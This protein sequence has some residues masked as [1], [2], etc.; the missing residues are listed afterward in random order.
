MCDTIVALGN[1][2]EDGTTIFAKN[3]D[4]EPNEAQGLIYIPRKDHD[5]SEIVKC[6]YIEVPQVPQTYEVLL[7]V[8]YWMWGAEMGVN[9][10]GVCIG[11]EAVFSKI[12]YNDTG[13]LGMDLLRL[14]LERSKTAD[15]A[16]NT[17][18]SLLE[19]FGQGGSGSV[20]DPTYKYHNSFIITDPKKAWVLETAGK[21]WVAEKVKDIRT[22]SN[23]YTIEKWDKA[24]P[25]IIEYAI[26]HNFCESKDEFNFIKCYSDPVPTVASNC[27]AR[28]K[29]TTEFLLDKKGTINVET[30]MKL[31][32]T[33]SNNNNNKEFNPAK[34]TMQICMHYSVNSLSQTVNSMISH[35]GDVHTH[36]FTCTSA[37][38]IGLFKPFFL[39]NIGLPKDY[40]FPNKNYDPNSLWWK[41][42][43]L[44]RLVLK[45]YTTRASIVQNYYK[46]EKTLV[47]KNNQIIKT[48]NNEQELNKNLENFST[49]SLLMQNIILDLL[50]HK[51]SKT[52]VKNK[53]SKIYLKKWDKLSKSIGLKL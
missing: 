15:E 33:H 52:P 7:S 2:T 12:P 28:Q 40:N 48:Y 25:N 8:P 13:L 24:S 42:E 4:R 3:S 35:L 1:S 14:A 6:T 34:A 30:M 36:W 26:E 11:N 27:E 51:I 23:G 10:W 50:I 41:H 16:L 49:I 9:E 29:N 5:K 18:I 31:L 43:K 37:P 32:R 44:H 45:D 38:C 47:S 20:I 22:I 21:L 39:R 53:V 19:K 46:F 17:I